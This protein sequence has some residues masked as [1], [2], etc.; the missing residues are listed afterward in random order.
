MVESNTKMSE[1]S[2]EEQFLQLEKRVVGYD[3]FVNCEE[4]HFKDTIEGFNKLVERIQMDNVFSSNEQLSEIHSE[5]L[6]LLMTPYY[7]ANVLLRMMENRD[8][9][10]KKGHTYYLEYLKLMNH[11]NLLNKEQ[12]AQWKAMYKVHVDKCAPKS[13]QI[14]QGESVY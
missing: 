6:K 2:L 9:N 5:N 1:G 3:D 10:V 7:Q 8:D 12:I 4:Q 11:Y 13:K 14:K